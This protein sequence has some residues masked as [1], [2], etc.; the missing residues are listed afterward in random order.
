MRSLRR[1]LGNRGGQAS[2]PLCEVHVPLSPTPG[3]FAQL[4]LLA[5]SLRTYGGALADA[6]IVVTVSRDCEP[7]DLDAH[8][9]WARR[10]GIEW[11]WMDEQQFA[12]T[13]IFGTA[14]QRF[15]Y[16]FE[17]PFVV[18]L[19]ADTFCTGPL[20]ELL[21]LGD[22]ALAGLVAHVSPAW[23]GTPAY[24][25]AI[26]D[27][28]RFWDGLYASAGLGTP[29]LACRHTGWSVMDGDPARR[30]CPPYF[31][32]G[33]LAGTRDVVARLGSRIYAEMAEVDR[34][35]DSVFRCQLAV[36]LALSRTG[37]AWR[38]LPPR[39]NYPNDE[40]FAA[41]YP[42]DAADVRILHY[43]R[44]DEIDRGSLATSRAQLDAFLARTDLSPSNEL[45]RSRIAALADQ[46]SI[47]A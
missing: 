19:D 38:E 14:V 28:A 13:G 7:Y 40:R 23:A 39:L 5:A 17:A 35:V 47:D 8:L 10:Y 42:G 26:T 44:G 2:G 24:T 4:Q 34:Y 46:L 16:D 12:R 3:F 43:L 30:D 37:V 27:D 36:T 9:P 41:A 32:L 11:R 21:E 29:P 45:L 6:R 33:V 1:L 18:L 15:T 31:N 20:D 25:G 22:R